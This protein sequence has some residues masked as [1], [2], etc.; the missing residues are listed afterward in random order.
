MIALRYLTVSSPLLPSRKIR[1]MPSASIELAK[2]LE[3]T[4]V[5]KHLGR[6]R[7]QKGL[8]QKGLADLCKLRQGE[9][10][11]FES[12][13]RHPTLAQLTELARSL[14][15]PLQWFITGSLEPSVA[16]SADWRCELRFRGIYDLPT[17]GAKVP[18]AFR[19]VEQLLTVVLRGDAVP[20]TIIESMPYLLATN[21]WR[22]RL[23][24]AYAREAGDPRVPSRLGWLADI[25]RSLHKAGFLSEAQAN[26]AALLTLT[27]KTSRAAKQDSLG[28]PAGDFDSSPIINSRWNMSYAGSL[29]QFKTR[30]EQLR[31]LRPVSET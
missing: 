15:A 5:G 21:H 27:K 8:T 3:W 12:G 7:R 22:S 24:L 18:G 28:H 14:D 26:R 13:R 11:A 1:N 2:L 10:S 16:N 20:K 30:V 19:P 9:I 6:A 4:E 17:E 23:M 29:D 25:S 31:A